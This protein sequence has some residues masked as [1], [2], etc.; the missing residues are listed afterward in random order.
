MICLK[1]A[2]G[3]FV[4]HGKPWIHSMTSMSA[5][6]LCMVHGRGTQNLS[7]RIQD[8]RTRTT[9]IWVMPRLRDGVCLFL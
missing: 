5:I 7:S 2:S 4:L 8:P 1:I 3:P 9:S 6:E